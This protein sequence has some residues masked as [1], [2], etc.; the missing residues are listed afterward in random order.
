MSTVNV[1]DRCETLVKAAALGA[2]TIETSPVSGRTDKEICPGCVE[3]FLT[4]YDGSHGNRPKAYSRPYEPP[5]SET[6]PAETFA[7]RVA[8]H[9][10]DDSRALPPSTQDRPRKTVTRPDDTAWGNDNGD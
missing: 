1:C 6:D 2:L 4:W 3:E 8:E 9:L 7:A 10:R 5:K